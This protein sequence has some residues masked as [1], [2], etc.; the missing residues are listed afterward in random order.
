MNYNPFFETSIYRECCK[1]RFDNASKRIQ[2]GL[3]NLVLMSFGT[4]VLCM[5]LIARQTNFW[6][7]T[8]PCVLWAIN[9]GLIW[10]S[11]CT[12]IIAEFRQLYWDVRILTD[13]IEQMQDNIGDGEDYELVGGKNDE[14]ENC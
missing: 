13:K 11:K 6:L 8:I 4:A 14:A 9:L 5:L 7:T 2:K 12:Q 1:H 3:F 10:N